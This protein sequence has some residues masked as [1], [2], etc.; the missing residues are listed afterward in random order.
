MKKYIAN[1]KI[2]NGEAT[3]NIPVTTEAETEEQAE[4][5]FKDY[6]CESDLEIWKLILFKEVKTFED[7]WEM[8]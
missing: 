1:F 3:Y 7:L 4:K 5:Y 8:I 2:Y 6:E